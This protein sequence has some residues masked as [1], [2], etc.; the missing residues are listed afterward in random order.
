M[1]K[2]EAVATCGGKGLKKQQ[3]HTTTTLQKND[4]VMKTERGR[5]KEFRLRRER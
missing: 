4:F 2:E 3:Q 5:E 1:E